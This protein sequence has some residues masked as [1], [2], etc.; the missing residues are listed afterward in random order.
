MPECGV[1]RRGGR[2]Q[3][4]AGFLSGRVCGVVAGQAGVLAMVMT[5]G[6]MRVAVSF[7]P[8]GPKDEGGLDLRGRCRARSTAVP[9]SPSLLGTALQHEVPRRLA[10]TARPTA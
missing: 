9:Y 10:D 8:A 7:A 1:S 6:A 3:G 4:P 5:A 2:V